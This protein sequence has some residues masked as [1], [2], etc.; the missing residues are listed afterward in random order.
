VKYEYE[1]RKKKLLL[2]KMKNLA[3]EYIMKLTAFVSVP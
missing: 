3:A 2:T 1:S